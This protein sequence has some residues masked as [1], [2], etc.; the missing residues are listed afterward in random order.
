M[1]YKYSHQFLPIFCS[2]KILTNILLS[3]IE[4]VFSKNLIRTLVEFGKK[5]VSGKQGVIKGK[6]GQ[7]KRRKC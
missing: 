7:K 2:H 3:S 4:V 5:M 6:N 1:G